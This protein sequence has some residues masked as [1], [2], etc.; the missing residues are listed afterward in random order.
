MWES[1]TL[2]ALQF[3]IVDVIFNVITV[4]GS[5][6]SYRLGNIFNFFNQLTLKGMMDGTLMDGSKCQVYVQVKNPGLF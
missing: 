6:V 1:W 3:I 5:A 2:I 4:I